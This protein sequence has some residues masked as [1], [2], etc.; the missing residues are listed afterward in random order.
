MAKKND[1][2]SSD[3]PAE[4]NRTLLKVIE[5][6]ESVYCT[7]DLEKIKV[8]VKDGQPGIE[9][10]A[11]AEIYKIVRFLLDEAGFH[12]EFLQLRETIHTASERM[13]SMLSEMTRGDLGQFLA[14][15][16]LQTRYEKEHPAPKKCVARF[17][18]QNFLNSKKNSPLNQSP[19]SCFVQASV[20]S[21]HLACELTDNHV[22]ITPGSLFYT[23]SIAFPLILLQ[24]RDDISVYTLCGTGYDSLCGG[25]F[26]DRDDQDARE[27]LKSLFKREKNPLRDAILTP[28]A[29]AVTSEHV[30]LFFTRQEI[31]EMVNIMVDCSSR[32]ILMSFRSRIFNSRDEA[33]QNFMNTTLH[34]VKPT[35]W[36]SKSPAPILVVADD[37]KDIRTEQEWKETVRRL[38]QQG[39]EVY[40]QDAQSKWHHTKRL[41][42]RQQ[43]DP[44]QNAAEKE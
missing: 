7:D 36:N 44:P 33:T 14:Q 9:P 37:E 26:P 21:I 5:L 15:G 10:R 25:W 22:A 24:Q 17:V 11:R 43:A 38:S 18:A 12:K 8:A 13:D 2:Q 4:E 34:Q 6:L 1:T 32:L 35:D 19:I 31:V 39:F 3:R 40:W 28:I 29:V 20:T 30:E 27:H 42:D 16:T 41:Q 23:N